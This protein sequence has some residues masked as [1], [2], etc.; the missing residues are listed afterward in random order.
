MEHDIIVITSNRDINSDYTM[1]RLR[2]L[3]KEAVRKLKEQQTASDEEVKS[4]HEKMN[5][6]G[7]I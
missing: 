3:I 4:L 2:A 5:K 7:I 1:R 6:V